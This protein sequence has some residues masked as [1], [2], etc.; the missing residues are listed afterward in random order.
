MPLPEMVQSN[1]PRQESG[2]WDERRL[3]LSV[4]A[5]LT[6]DFAENDGRGAL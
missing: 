1:L 5:Q 3:R 4:G 6:S 2:G